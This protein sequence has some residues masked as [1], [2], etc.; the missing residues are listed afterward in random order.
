MLVHIDR[1]MDD[2]STLQLLPAELLQKIVLYL[3]HASRLAL[4]LCCKNVNAKLAGRS[5]NKL[6]NYVMTALLFI[7]Q[8]P[9][10]CGTKGREGPEAEP[11]A[12]RDFFTCHLCLRI[13]S[14]IK[15]PNFMIKGNRGKPGFDTLKRQRYCI[16]CGM[17]H[18]R[19]RRGT[20]MKFGGATGGWG[21]LCQN[22][23]RFV[24]AE[25]IHPAERDCANCTGR[26]LDPNDFTGWN[27]AQADELEKELA[28]SSDPISHAG[29]RHG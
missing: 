17:R 21:L 22:C 8:W 27:Y 5:T 9:A 11:L 25:Q 3:P 19:W 4:Y 18:R 28:S 12:G 16:P 20:I 2:L 6:R 13:R 7:E 1:K 10:Y 29:N 24:M 26:G 14:A 23:G 15:F